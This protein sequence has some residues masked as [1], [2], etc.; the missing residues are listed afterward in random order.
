[1]RWMEEKGT[2]PISIPLMNLPA[3][4]CQAC[5]IYVVSHPFVKLPT[6]VVLACCVFLSKRL[7]WMRATPAHSGQS[8]SVI[9]FYL[10]QIIF[11]LFFPK[12][13]SPLKLHSG[14]IILSNRSQQDIAQTQ[15]TG[16]FFT[17]WLPSYS[18]GCVPTNGRYVTDSRHTRVLALDR[19]C[20]KSCCVRNV[21]RLVC[22]CMWISALKPF[23]VCVCVSQVHTDAVFQ[24]Q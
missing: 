1:M 2:H 24:K 10:D 20:S 3:A 22:G 23:C 16:S 6:V 8:P 4:A 5:P 7:L 19:G 13:I 11:S 14:F 12:F 18:A 9:C 15:Q 21:H 17:G